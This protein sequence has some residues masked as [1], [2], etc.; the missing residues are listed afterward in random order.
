MCTVACKADVWYTRDRKLLCSR[1]VDAPLERVTSTL[2]RRLVTV[3]ILSSYV[4]QDKPHYVYTLAYP[5]S[6]GGYVFYIGKG[7]GRRITE[8]EQRVRKGTRR[9]GDNLYKEGVIKKIWEAGEEVI[10]VK[11]AH[12]ATNDEALEYEA[13]LIILMRGCEH[14]TNLS[15]GGEGTGRLSLSEE[16]RRKVS[17]ASKG[18]RHSLETRKRMSEAAKKRGF[19][20]E[21]RRKVNE[22]LKG[23][24]HS[25]ETRRKMSQSQK[26][27][28]GT[29]EHRRKVSEDQKKRGDSYHRKQSEHAKRQWQKHHELYGSV[30]LGSC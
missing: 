21:H 10:R 9:Q 3:N 23:K 8:H 6:M 17:E 5:E 20:A 2:L 27:R 13:A 18:R 16:A 28:C 29:E 24:I 14:L 19:T 15:D 1:D 22:S 11:L 4:P 7:Y 26:L 30:P 12:F 25:Q